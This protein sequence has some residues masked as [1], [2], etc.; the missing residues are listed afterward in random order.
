LSR[1]NHIQLAENKRFNTSINRGESP[2]G[3]PFQE[4]AEQKLVL[5]QQ[6]ASS[7]GIV[8]SQDML[9]AAQA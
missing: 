8:F 2:A 9:K 1:S 6:V 5:N 3:I 4:V 7:L